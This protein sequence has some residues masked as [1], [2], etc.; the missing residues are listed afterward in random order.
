MELTTFENLV[1]LHNE[2]IET[3]TIFYEKKQN[4]RDIIQTTRERICTEKEET[5]EKIRKY[6]ANAVD[7]SRPQSVR[8]MAEIEVEN[9]NKLE[10]F[11]TDEEIEIFDTEYEKAD[12]IHTEIVRLKNA[13]IEA[14]TEAW[15]EIEAAQKESRFDYFYMSYSKWLWELQSEFSG[16]ISEEE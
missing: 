6:E 5:A 16:L 7:D 2:Y 12:E 1:R 13:V 3:K 11:A 4:L 14:F 15:R 8:R 9:L 10:F